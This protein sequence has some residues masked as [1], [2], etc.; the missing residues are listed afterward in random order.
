MKRHNRNQKFQ[1]AHIVS[2]TEASDQ[3]VQF[4]AVELARFQLYQDSLRSPSTPIT[5]I[6]ELGNPN[7]CFVYSSS[8]ERV[9]DS[10]ATDHMTGNSSLSLPFSH[11]L[12]LPLSL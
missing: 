7:K 11:N 8:S 5:A 12:H 6:A 2:T 3:L 4:L 10:G 9:I 1:Y